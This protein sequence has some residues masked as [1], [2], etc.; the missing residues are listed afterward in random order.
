MRNRLDTIYMVGIG[1]SGMCGIAEVLLNLGYSVQG[2]D[3]TDST[4]TAH[5]R[6]LGAQ[7]YIG[8]AAEHVGDVS[9]LVR[10][11]AIPDDNPEIVAAR[12]RGIPVIPRAEMLAELMRLRTGI[13]IAGTHGKTSTTSMTMGRIF[14]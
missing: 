4:V 10:S 3:M 12:A 9:V 6:S 5:L 2:S 7:I 14:W 1:G 13:A 11:S 8:H